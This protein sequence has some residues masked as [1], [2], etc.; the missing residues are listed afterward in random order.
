MSKVSP[1]TSRLVSDEEIEDAA[2]EARDKYD[3]ASCGTKRAERI[4]GFMD[5]FTEGAKWSLNRECPSV[6]L[7]FDADDLKRLL[8]AVNALDEAHQAHPMSL[9]YQGLVTDLMNAA[10]ALFPLDENL[11]PQ[12]K[13]TTVAESEPIKREDT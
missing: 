6:D 7:G 9:K 13:L 12:V 4:S 8:N 3:K 1:S 11:T 2:Y 5:G 10:W